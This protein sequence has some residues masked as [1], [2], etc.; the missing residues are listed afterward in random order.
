MKHKTPMQQPWNA[1]MFQ[2]RSCL[3]IPHIWLAVPT[4]LQAMTAAPPPQT[5]GEQPV[6]TASTKQATRITHTMSA[7]KAAFSTHKEKVILNYI[8]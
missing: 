6:E 3:G 8:A 2:R 4:S 7:T 1:L 5:S